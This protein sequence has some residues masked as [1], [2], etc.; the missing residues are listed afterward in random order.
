MRTLERIRASA[1]GFLSSTRIL[2]RP[3][4]LGTYVEEH[5][6]PSDLPPGRLVVV[7]D[8]K[9]E[10]NACFMCPGACGQ[11]LILS[12]SKSRKPRWNVSFDRLGRPTVL[13]SVRQL[14]PCK[15][16]FWIRKGEVTWCDDS[17]HRR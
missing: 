5:P 15:C 16:H 17:L 14:G 8:G 6:T 11:K 12:M 2:R 3:S 9:I 7:R 10:K 1:I 13:P 4:F